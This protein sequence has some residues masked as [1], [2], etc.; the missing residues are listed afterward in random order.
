M[1][2]SATGVVWPGRFSASPKRS[3]DPNTGGRFTTLTVTSA[4]AVPPWPSATA[5]RM[6]TRPIRPGAV[7]SASGPSAGPW[8]VPCP[9]SQSYVIGS[10]SGSEA[11]ALSRTSPPRGTVQGSQTAC[12]VGGLFRGVTSSSRMVTSI[13]AGLPSATSAGRVPSATVNVSSSASASS[14]VETVPVPVVCPLP[15]VM[16]ASDPKSPASAVPAVSMSGIVTPLPNAS[17]SRA[18][19]VTGCPSSTGF[20]ETDRL[21]VGVAGGVVILVKVSLAMR[22]LEN[23]PVP[24][25][26]VTTPCGFVSGLESENSV[27]SSVP[28]SYGKRSTTCDCRHSF[29]PSSR[30]TPETPTNQSGLGPIMDRSVT[31]GCVLVTSMLNVALPVPPPETPCSTTDRVWGLRAT[32]PR[33]VAVE[34]S[35]ATCSTPALARD[36]AC[37]KVTPLPCTPPIRVVKCAP[38]TT[39][40]GVLA[41]VQLPSNVT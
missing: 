13:D 33:K 24:A 17:D 21:T 1:R 27:P 19:T 39:P 31:R 34:P 28:A 2:P 12:T 30:D 23:L 15:M 9:A 26:P 14:A 11:S 3:G 35:S 25:M 16:L 41:S 40:P 29:E 4:T 7:Q 20:G 22:T 37:Q 36:P 38:A 8:K 5:T 18:V 6:T 10:P 32:S